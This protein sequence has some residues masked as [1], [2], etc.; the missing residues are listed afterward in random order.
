MSL[1]QQQQRNMKVLHAELGC[2]FQVITWAAGRAIGLYLTVVFRPYEHGALGKAKKIKVSKKLLNTPKFWEKGCSSISAHPQ[3]P[4][5]GGRKHCL[6]VG[7]DSTDYA[8]S[9][10]EKL[11]LKTVLL[12]LIKE[13]KARYGI[14]AQ[15]SFCDNTVE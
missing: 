5:L 11:G 12:S 3:L 1:A 9:L 4:L 6:F 15:Y 8:W 13:L 7:V 2:P 10:K 14:H